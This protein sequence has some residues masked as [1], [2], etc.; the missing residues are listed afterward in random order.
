MDTHQNM[1]TVENMV[2]DTS[3]NAWI[4]AKEY[5]KVAMPQKRG[6]AARCLL[7]LWGFVK[8]IICVI[9]GFGVAAEL[10]TEYTPWYSRM[11][12]AIMGSFPFWPF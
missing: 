10:F 9:L 6:V 12:N 4:S 1:H 3:T 5:A 2:F 8:F 7:T 11:W